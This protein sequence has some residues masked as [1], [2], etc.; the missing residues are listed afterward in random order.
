MSGTG[1]V[2]DKAGQWLPEAGGEV[3][4]DCLVGTGFPFGSDENAPE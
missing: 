2:V 1:K 3:R 4:S